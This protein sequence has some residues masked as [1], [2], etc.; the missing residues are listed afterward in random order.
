MAYRWPTDPPGKKAAH[1]I[2]WEQHQKN[3]KAKQAPAPVAPTPAMTP[4]TVPMP[5]PVYDADVLNLGRARDIAVANA[6]AARASGLLDYGFTENAGTG[7]LTFDPNNPFSRAAV[8]KQNY[9]Q[10]RARA[11]QTM[12]SGGQLYSG[13]FQ[14]QQ[15]FIN[16]GQLQS[17]DALQKALAGFL[18]ENTSARQRALTEHQ[19][20]MSSVEAE[21]AA[22]ALDNPLYSPIPGTP[23]PVPTAGGVS[24][25]GA[26]VKGTHTPLG[27]TKKKAKVKTY[28][29]KPKGG[30]KP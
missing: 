29:N 25:T 10:S 11:A 22:R 3:L 16:R 1:T 6:V 12:G 15:D 14:N 9:N 4:P 8:L 30:Y 2:S 13:A 20:G 21:R 19:M 24:A 26:P 17:E 28:T 27:P 5:D 18:A 23:A 7:A